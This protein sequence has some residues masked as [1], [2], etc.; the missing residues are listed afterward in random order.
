MDSIIVGVVTALVTAF[1]A[2]FLLKEQRRKLGAEADSILVG[3]AGE[4]VKGLQSEVVRLRQCIEELEA[5]QKADRAEIEELR[6]GV[7]RLTMENQ[8]LR[9][10]VDTLEAENRMLREENEKL[11]K[12]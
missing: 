2:F 3:A 4:V 11:R 10:R 6:V 9:R 7:N 5:D 8:T 12:P 1:T